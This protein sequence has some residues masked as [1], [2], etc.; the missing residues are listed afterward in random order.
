MPLTPP[1]NKAHKYSLTSDLR[2][3]KQKQ[4]HSFGFTQ[5]GL[6]FKS[7][8]R[9]ENTVCGPAKRAGLRPPVW[10][11]FRI[12]LRLRGSDVRL[13]RR[14]NL[15][16]SW[17]LQR[18]GAHQTRPLPSAFCGGP[19]Y[20]HK[21]PVCV[22]PE[23]GGGRRKPVRPWKRKKFFPKGRPLSFNRLL[24][25]LFNRLVA[26]AI[27]WRLGEIRVYLFERLTSLQWCVGLC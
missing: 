10:D 9:G 11:S 25:L 17:R 21:S 8:T 14:R 23:S 24:N 4:T 1:Q 22:L 15:R 26:D 5:N 16:R 19:P 20:S 27:F 13:W 12:F 7:P 18:L 6:V 2:S 3:V